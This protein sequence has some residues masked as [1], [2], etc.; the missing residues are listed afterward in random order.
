MSQFPELEELEAFVATQELLAFES[1]NIRK[2]LISEY[3]GYE[4][5]QRTRFEMPTTVNEVE[6]RETKIESHWKLDKVHRGQSTFTK[7]GLKTTIVKLKPYKMNMRLSLLITKP[8][9]WK[10]LFIGLQD[11]Y[12]K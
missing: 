6:Q 7:P 10:R 1:E 9:P 4:S 5:E 11:L 3:L 2:D 12:W 8:P